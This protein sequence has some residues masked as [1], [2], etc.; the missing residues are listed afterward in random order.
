M[1]ARRIFLDARQHGVDLIGADAG[2][3]TIAPTDQHAPANVGPELL[4]VGLAANAELLHRGQ[5]LLSR[6]AGL[7][8]ER[9]DLGLNHGVAHLDL[10]AGELL[11]LQA[12]VNDRPQR[13]LLDR[14]Q[15]LF[16]RLQLRGEDQQQH[17]LA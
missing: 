14:R 7:L 13:L 9:L 10:E 3:V 5:H 6:A 16:G 17:A 2:P 15:V 12:L 8:G 11:R 1:R 4:D